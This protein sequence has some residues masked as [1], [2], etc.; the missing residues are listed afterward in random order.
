LRSG[1][2]LPSP[3]AED[4]RGEL[5]WSPD[6]Q[7][8]AAGLANGSVVLVD[9]TSG[10]WPPPLA[11]FP[12]QPPSPIIQVAWA[13]QGE[14]LLISGTGGLAAVWDAHRDQ[15]ELLNLSVDL[16]TWLPDG[17][18]ILAGHGRANVKLGFDSQSGQ[19]LG[20]LIPV[21]GGAQWMVISPEG[22]Y[23]GSESLDEHLV[24]VALTDDGRQET[25]TPAEFAAKFGWKNDPSH[26]RLL[27]TAP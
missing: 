5:T 27:K 6:G 7:R 16:A 1:E 12:D 19:R 26:A 22:H 18:Q 3:L 11:P 24:Y 13:P 25:Y 2:P 17:R 9:Q 23:R 8:I 10:R 21:L 15:T 4:P 14:R 20:T